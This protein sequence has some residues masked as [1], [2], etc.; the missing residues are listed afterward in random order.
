M[1]FLLVTP[2]L[3][4]EAFLE[5]AI[6]SVRAQSH[7]DFEYMIV[8]GGSTDASCAIARKAASEDDRIQ[9]L[10]RPGLNQYASIAAGFDAGEGDVLAWLNA[11]DLYA[12]WALAVVAKYAA[13]HPDSQWLTGLPGCW[14]EDDVLRFVRPDAWRPRALIRRGWHHKDLIGFIQQESVFFS[15]DLFARLSAAQRSAFERARLAGDFILWKAFADAVPLEVI[16]TVLGGFRRHGA[17]R[18]VAGMDDYMDEVKNAGATFLPGPLAA[19][20]RAL[21]VRLSVRMTRR[22]I[23]AEDVH[24]L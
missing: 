14:D 24:E 7:E 23:T 13:R 3:N 16:P 20:A 21:H 1:R 2:V 17:N 4:G 9:L 15:K 8:D 18:S 12:P 6:A 19:M 5:R 11:D 22:A 10:E